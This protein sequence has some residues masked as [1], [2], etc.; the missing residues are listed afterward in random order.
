MKAILKYKNYK[1]TAELDIL[2]GVYRG[3]FLFIVDLVT[4]IADRALEL[5]KE[6][7]AAVDDYIKT[8]QLISK[9]TT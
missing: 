8:C 7:E 5:Q 2:R 4:Y 3:K 6:F 9:E 1:R